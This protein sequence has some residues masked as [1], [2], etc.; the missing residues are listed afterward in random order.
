[1]NIYGT[2]KRTL[3]DKLY[4]LLDDETCDMSEVCTKDELATQ[5]EKILE[6]YTLVLKSGVIED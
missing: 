2:T 1:M 6:D 5:F 4:N 3:S